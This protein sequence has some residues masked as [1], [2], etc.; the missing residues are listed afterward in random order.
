[1]NE[2]LIRKRIRRISTAALLIAFTVIMTRLFVIDAGFA[3]I[4]LGAVPVM[5]SSI[6]LGPIYGAVV[7]ISADILGNGIK[8]GFG[9]TLPWPIISAFIN[10]VLPWLIFKGLRKIKHQKSK[11]P[12]IV[13]F[14]FIVWLL[15]S[16]I[17]WINPSITVPYG[18]GESREIIFTT[19]WKVLLPLGLFVLLF[20]LFIIV[21]FIN[22]YFKSRP[23]QNEDSPTPYEVALF[24]FITSFIVRVVWTPIWKAFTIYSSHG[25]LAIL[26]LD[27]IIF[28]ILY[29]FISFFV[30]FLLSIY[31]RYIDNSNATRVNTSK[32][33]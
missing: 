10:G 8:F 3:R 7:G 33:R 24:V 31:Y 20:T 5:L 30:S 21:Y 22:K 18:S 25:Y 13:Y 27:S 4:S 28:I 23:I 19:Q 1:M 2:P 17:V 12:L 32:E 29:P 16:L 26:A 11:I 14:F 15:I 9:S 6:I